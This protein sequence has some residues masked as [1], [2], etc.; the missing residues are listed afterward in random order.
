MRLAL[1]VRVLVVCVPV[2]AAQR[3][4]FAESAQH[5]DRLRVGTSLEVLRHGP[6]HAPASAHCVMG[7]GGCS[8]PSFLELAQRGQPG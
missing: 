2:A 8:A 5:H 7:E 3:Y 1:F 6:S 4:E